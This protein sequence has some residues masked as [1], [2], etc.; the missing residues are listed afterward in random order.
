MKLSFSE[1]YWDVFNA[2]QIAVKVAL[3]KNGVAAPIPQMTILSAN[4]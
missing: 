2:A 3:E 4:R 1:D